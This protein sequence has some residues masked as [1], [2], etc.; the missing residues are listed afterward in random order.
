VPHHRWFLPES[1][2]VLGLLRHQMAVT[3]E[4]MDAFAAW[5][6]GDSGAGT[7]VRELE[8]RADDAKREL[9]GALRAAFVT[10]LEPEDLFALSRGVDRILNEAKDLVRESEVMA[11]PPDTA[12]AEMGTLLA[13]SVRSL[14]DAIARLDPK[15]GD[16]TEAANAAIKDDRRLER[17][18]RAAMATLLDV[19]DLREVMARRELYR[20]CSRIGEASVDVAERVLYAV[21]KES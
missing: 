11:C 13:A 14:D 19:D 16:A 20:R 17:V 12:V 4:G 8:H 10:P 2:D 9:H 5:A 1:P 6:A 3:I 7:A 15:A 18:Y 21:V